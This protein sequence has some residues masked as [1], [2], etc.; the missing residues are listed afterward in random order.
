MMAAV[1]YLALGLVIVVECDRPYRVEVERLRAEADYHAEEAH[2]SSR[3]DES[4]F[5]A[6]QARSAAI[7]LRFMTRA[8]E[9]ERIMP[10][11]SVTMPALVVL[12]LGVITWV[13]RPS[14]TWQSI[15]PSPPLPKRQP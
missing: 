10:I 12:L 2:I 5:H 13:W 4:A 3:A 15:E 9:Q 11:L 14:K 1:V 6:E 7:Q 8:R